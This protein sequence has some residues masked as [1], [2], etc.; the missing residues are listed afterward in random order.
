MKIHHYVSCFVVRSTSSGSH[1]FLQMLRVRSKYMGGTWQLVTGGIDEGETAWQAALRE[2]RE[3]TGLVPIEFYQVDVLN[4]FYLAKTDTISMSPMFCAIVPCDAR[5]T[6]NDEH[7]DFRWVPRSEIESRIMWPGERAA[8]KEL[9]CEILDDGP[10]KP[11]L[12]I[13]IPQSS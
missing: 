3:E 1:E 9:C 10:A 7:T 12:K 11:Y 8:L 5:I 13:E 2:L 4:T 6:L